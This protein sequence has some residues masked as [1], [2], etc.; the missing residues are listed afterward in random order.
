MFW[1]LDPAGFPTVDMLGGL[2]AL[3]RINLLQKKR[4]GS[5]GP[6]VWF[7][8]AWGLCSLSTFNSCCSC[9]NIIQQNGFCSRAQSTTHSASLDFQVGD[10]LKETCAIICFIPGGEKRLLNKDSSK[11]HLRLGIL[12]NAFTFITS[13]TPL[14]DP[15]H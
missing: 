7:V 5:E 4:N 9:R 15:G 14:Q 10:T 8:L 1:I 12:L 6:D 13:S 11:A 2:I 3:S